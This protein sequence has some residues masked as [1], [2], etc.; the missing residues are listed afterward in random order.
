MIFREHDWDDVNIEHIAGHGVIPQEVEEACFNEPL[1]RK[2]R[3]NRYIVYGRNDSGRYL[4]IVTIYKG[5]GVV[6]VITARDMTD[7]EHRLYNRKRG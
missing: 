7:S 2:I 3:K 4:F 6:R 1:V 5:K